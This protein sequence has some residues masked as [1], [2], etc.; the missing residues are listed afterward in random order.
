MSIKDSIPANS[1]TKNDPDKLRQSVQHILDQI[2]KV[3][4]SEVDSL[5]VSILNKNDED[6][7]IGMAGNLRG[8]KDC[9]TEVVLRIAQLQGEPPTTR[10][11]GFAVDPSRMRSFRGSE[12]DADELGPTEGGA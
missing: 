11:A 3:E 7:L 5:V 1:A 8:L 6:N 10:E 9:T 2:A 4:A 12:A